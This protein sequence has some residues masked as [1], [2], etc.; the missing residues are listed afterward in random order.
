MI[1]I[2][3]ILIS[4]FIIRYIYLEFKND[5]VGRIILRPI[6]RAIH[7][8]LNTI[9]LQYKLYILIGL[10]GYIIYNYYTYYIKFIKYNKT[11]L[12]DEPLN[13][14]TPLVIPSSK[15]SLTPANK[16]KQF[17]ISMNIFIENWDYRY[18]EEKVL[19]NWSNNI[20]SGI[21]IMLMDRKGLGIMFYR[22][23]E[24]KTYLVKSDFNIPLQTDVEL[25]FVLDNYNISIFVNGELI[26]S[27]YLDFIFEYGKGYPMKLN[28]DGGFMGQINTLEY[29]PQTILLNKIKKMD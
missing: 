22:Y 18:Y 24:N 4:I 3:G 13:G 11:I 25:T 27:E 5:V 21:K 28:E 14:Q 20:D 9:V 10:I 2:I 7:F 26:R 23:G 29:I 1:L 6:I 19:V 8:I 16:G 17:V 12:I 15:L